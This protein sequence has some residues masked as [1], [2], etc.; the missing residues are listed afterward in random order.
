[1]L[2]LNTLAKRLL[3][4][5]LLLVFAGMAVFGVVMV[6]QFTGTLTTQAQKGVRQNVDFIAQVSST[7][8]SNYDLTALELFVKETSKD[9]DVAY[10]EFFD[11]EG[12]SLTADISKKGTPD[13]PGAMKF[14]QAIK[15]S[16]GKD[17][18]KLKLAYKTDSIKATRNK[19]SAITAGGI[20]MV[21]VML[22]VGLLWVVR[23]IVHQI[24]GEPDYATA[25]VRKIAA[26]DLACDIQVKG[27][28]PD[29][30]LLALKSMSAQLYNTVN[31]IQSVA[32]A[33]NMA[34]SEIA[35]GNSDL[36]ART[37][38]QASNL[39]QTASSMEQ[40]TG[41]VKQNADAARQASQLASTASEI[42]SKGGSVVGNVVTTMDDIA[43]ASKKI[44]D[45]IGVIDGIAF[46][47]NILAL[48]AAVEAARAG[49]QG[50]GFAV[51][52][53]EV[54]S[55]A[56][57][58]AEAAKEIKT[59]IGR[60]VEKVDTGSRLVADAGQTMNEIVQSVKRVTD[61]I[62]EISASTQEQSVG[63]TSVNQSVGQLDQM[64]Q[65]NAAL[66]EQSAA[67]AESLKDQA[68]KLS[69]AV[70]VFHLQAG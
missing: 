23:R 37:E 61:I 43:H 33:I 28:H 52:A 49:E 11:G 48:N 53:S 14:E 20:I 10:M 2:K 63:I 54:R 12:K 17:V 29:S 4:P 40:M 68:A 66:V 22:T 60:S 24:G 35:T 51:V 42:A 15:D 25:V 3:A 21:L 16:S 57:R 70:S 8:I 34:S 45:I 30:L 13:L 59:L 64:T 65:Q 38:Q 69:E 58:S 27:N 6:A 7:Y 9:P 47:T 41:T 31:D 18:G 56:Q 46:Q 32:T 67:A 44:G 36:S 1:M 19:A 62:S 50:R 39:Q 26:G 55:L 5:A